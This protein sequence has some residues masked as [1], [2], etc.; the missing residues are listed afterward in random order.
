M[1]IHL[2][3]SIEWLE[4][5]LKSFNKEENREEY[6]E[7]MFWMPYEAVIEKL[8]KLKQG[9]FKYIPSEWCDNIQ[10]DGSCW[11]HDK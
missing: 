6:C 7:N 8:K 1:K 5:K 11:G 2:S 10:K 4:N 9:D 3:I